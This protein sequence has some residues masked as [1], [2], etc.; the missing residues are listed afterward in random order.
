MHG[1]VG[2][3]FLLTTIAGLSTGIGSALAMFTRRTNRTILSAALGF[4][5]GVMV[6][7]SFVELFPHA[8]KTLEG[9]Y[10]PKSA[11]WITTG[12]FFGGVALILVIDW[13]VPSYENPHEAPAAECFDASDALVPVRPAG[14]EARLM[15][16]G[17]M[18]ALVI[19]IHN[20]PEGMATF[21]SGLGDTRIA[22]SITVAIALHNIPEG[23]A[24][25]VPIFFAT[26]SRKRAFWLSALSGLSEPAGALIGW[27]VLRPFLSDTLFGVI[28]ASIAGIMVFISLDELIPTAREYGKGHAS[29]YGLVAGMAVMAL[30]LLMA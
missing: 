7:I 19:G 5:A 15:R 3:A 24:V 18:T 12:A 22:V 26:G 25:A 16:V 14:D 4:S 9:V 10:A 13:L 21:A 11:A 27:L 8:L 17:V 29:V 6:Y 1:S 28:F 23:I 2:L 30:S 20:F